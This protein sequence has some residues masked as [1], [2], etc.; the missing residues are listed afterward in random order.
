MLPATSAADVVAAELPATPESEL[1][2][3][4]FSTLIS[5]FLQAVTSAIA[6]AIS[7]FLGTNPPPS[8]PGTSVS[9]TGQPSLLNRIFTATLGWVHSLGLDDAATTALNIVTATPPALLNQAL[10]VSQTV[11]NGIP[12]FV[13]APIAESSGKYV[14]AVHGGAYV[15]EPTVAHWWSYAQMVQ[16]TGATVVV[17]IYPLAPEGTAATVVPSIAALISQQIER[18]GAANVSLIGDSAGGGLALAAAQLLVS[19]GSTVPASIVLQ[20]PWVD[21]SLTNPDIATVNDPVLDLA[22]TKANGVSWAGS[23]D[24]TNPLV[25]PLY[26]ELSRLPPTYVYAGSDELLAPD[27]LLLQQNAVAA[28]APFSFT[29]RVGEIH[30]WA[31]MPFLDGADVQPQIYQQLGLNPDFT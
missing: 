18:Y 13:L 3:V 19:N 1:E 24:L 25:S 30:D 29:L 22:V 15:A 16:E 4:G 27:M 5:Q 10:K 17:P 31:L 28:G 7:S 26:G 12:S 2:P 23:L 6:T 21:V 9:F 14:V 11:L 8:S 20:S